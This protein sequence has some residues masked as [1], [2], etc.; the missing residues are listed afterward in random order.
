VIKKISMAVQKCVAYFDDSGHPDSQ[1]AVLVAG[2]VAQVEQWSLLEKEW[3][4]DLKEFKLETFHMKDFLNRKCTDYEHLSNTDKKRLLGRL[5][6]HIRTRTRHSFCSIVPMADYKEV[7]ANYY[8]EEILGKPY[9]FAAVGVIQRL[10]A[11]KDKYASDYPLEIILEDGTKHK[12]DLMKVFKQFHF[13]DPIF[14]DRKHLPPLQAADM[15]AW[16]CFDAFMTG[17][18]GKTLA[19]LLEVPGREGH[20]IFT[21]ERLVDACRDADVKPRDPNKAIE[22]YYT[23]EPKVKRLRQILGSSSDHKIRGIE[24]SGRLEK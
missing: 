6:G 2:W 20:G 8:F 1:D 23:S 21:T 19:D 15:L 17:E 12:G 4:E 7:N 18:V 22:F 10:R 16:G 14:R 9:A 3:N 24:R 5:V 13:N 11:W